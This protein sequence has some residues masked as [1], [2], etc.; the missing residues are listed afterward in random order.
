VAKWH[1]KSLGPGNR[2]RGTAEMI[3][4]KERGRGCSGRGCQVRPKCCRKNP[5]T[6]P[7]GSVNGS[8]R[9]IARA[10]LGFVISTLSTTTVI[11]MITD[12]LVTQPPAG[13]PIPVGT[14]HAPFV[15]HGDVID[16]IGWAELL[17]GVCAMR[18]E[19]IQST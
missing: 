10:P 7:N 5:P 19:H 11:E 4:E 13:C 17:E 1:G 2:G 18:N 9:T 15:N 16:G 14:G 12:L 3:G 6:T 8:E